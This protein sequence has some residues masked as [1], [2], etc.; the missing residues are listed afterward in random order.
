M[1]QGAN[2]AFVVFCTSAKAKGVSGKR[3]AR[4]G[5]LCGNKE[6][7]HKKD[8]GVVLQK[9]LRLLTKNLAT[10]RALYKTVNT[11]VLTE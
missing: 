8:M 10:A 3:K 4:V 7:M 9:N 11:G 2:C 5:V 6:N 1:V